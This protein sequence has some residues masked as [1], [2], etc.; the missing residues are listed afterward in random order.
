MKR[1]RPNVQ[2]AASKLIDEIQKPAYNL[3]MICNWSW[4]PAILKTLVPKDLLAKTYF[5]PKESRFTR[6]LF[7][8]IAHD[9]QN[10]E[11][12]GI[13]IRKSVTERLK[14]NPNNKNSFTCNSQ[15][16]R[17]CRVGG[18][19]RKRIENKLE[20][21]AHPTNQK[22]DSIESVAEWTK[23]SRNFLSNWNKFIFREILAI[24]H[25]I[26]AIQSSL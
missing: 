23:I 21:S 12:I 11:A 17:D 16:K 1:R 14:W 2:I 20:V 6:I 13:S 19:Y 8:L 24:D 22:Q 9:R 3:L 4:S 25:L 18:K 7:F 5:E 26:E 10:A 15:L